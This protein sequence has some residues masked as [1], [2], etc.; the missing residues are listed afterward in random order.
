VER[1]AYSYQG[2]QI[3]IR[4]VRIWNGEDRFDETVTTDRCTYDYLSV[5]S[6]VRNID[7]TGMK[8][9]DN[10]YIQFISGRKLVDMYVIYLGTSSLKANNGKQYEVINISMTIKDDAFTSQQEALKASLT[11]D[12]NRIPVVIDTHLKVGL[13]HAVLKNVSGLRH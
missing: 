2:D 10:R 6:Y 4:A 3:T 13:V 9:G 8:P 11:N 12:E 1:Q 5:L 7:Y